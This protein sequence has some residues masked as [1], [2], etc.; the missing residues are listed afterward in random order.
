MG[1]G[2]AGPS[3]G[4]TSGAAPRAFSAPSNSFAPNRSF[5]APNRSFAAPNGATAFRDR[6]FRDR[7]HRRF[8][9][10]AFGGAPFF[11]GGY[12][13]DYGPDYAYDYDYDYGYDNGCF[14][15]RRFFYRGNWHTRRVW[16]CG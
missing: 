15:L 9:G 13:Y 3:L 10:F 16:V 8:R 2:R 6:G 14:A 5:A 1:M 7:D 4:T 11:W 12:G